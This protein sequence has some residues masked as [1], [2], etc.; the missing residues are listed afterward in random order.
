M[1][2]A[3]TNRLVQ[4]IRK[5]REKICEMRV[6]E[7]PEEEIHVALLEL[8]KIMDASNQKLGLGKI[9][10]IRLETAAAGGQW[11]FSATEPQRDE[12]GEFQIVKAEQKVE[13]SIREA[14]KLLRKASSG[15]IDM[16]TKNS[17]NGEY[18]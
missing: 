16:I 13:N 9:E 3:Q 12:K 10:H 17:L 6:N 4:T 2:E 7:V 14:N 1:T 11:L 8:K 5:Q 15:R 18:L